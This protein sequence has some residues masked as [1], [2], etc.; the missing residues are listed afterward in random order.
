MKAQ[1]SATAYFLGALLG[2]MQAK[3]LVEGVPCTILQK[4]KKEDAAKMIE[5]LKADCGAEFELV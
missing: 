5:K 4:V 2:S 1:H 3:D